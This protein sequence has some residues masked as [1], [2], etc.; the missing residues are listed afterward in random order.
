MGEV[1]GAASALMDS[2][3]DLNNIE[4]NNQSAHSVEKEYLHNDNQKSLE[5][6]QQ[7]PLALNSKEKD[8]VEPDALCTEEEEVSAAAAAVE[9]EHIEEK[10]KSSEKKSLEQI[11]LPD[12]QIITP[13]SK[14]KSTDIGENKSFCSTCSAEFTAETGSGA[15][16]IHNATKNPATIDSQPGIVSLPIDSLHTIASFLSPL[17][18]ASFGGV[19]KGSRR[20][21]KEIFRRVRMHGFRCATEVVTAWVS[22]NWN[23]HRESFIF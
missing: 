8:F 17:E 4:K 2:D 12:D 7:P 11:V 22:S 23:M 19:S 10:S 6:S 15:P 5:S 9:H 18:W 16:G 13:K 20:I 14:E 3:L 21:C 1:D